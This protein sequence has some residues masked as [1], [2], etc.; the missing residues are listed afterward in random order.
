[1]AH[2]PNTI[3]VDILMRVHG[4]SEAHEVATVDLPVTYT[5]GEPGQARRVVDASPLEDAGKALADALNKV[6][7]DDA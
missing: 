4:S 1:M 6:T 2:T 7:H 3:K 5:S